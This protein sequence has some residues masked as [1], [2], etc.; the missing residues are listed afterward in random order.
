MKVT[1]ISDIPVLPITLGQELEKGGFTVQHA[2]PDNKTFE[3]P[4]ACYGAGLSQADLARLVE[5]LSP[6]SLSPLSDPNLASDE[7]RLN[8]YLPENLNTWELDIMAD[9]QSL[10]NK[11]KEVC[12]DSFG[13]SEDESEISVIERNELIYGSAPKQVRQLIRWFLKTQGI[14]VTEK[15]KF[16]SSDNDIYIHV[17]D[18][19]ADK[20]P[21]SS[22]RTPP[23]IRPYRTNKRSPYWPAVWGMSLEVPSRSRM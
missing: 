2:L 18:P 14:I 16:S 4:A 9:T 19:K 10:L 3:S 17:K 21:P 7:V 22:F 13:F 5:M 1:I 23:G 20:L 11:V 6:L 12:V 15:Q 8:L